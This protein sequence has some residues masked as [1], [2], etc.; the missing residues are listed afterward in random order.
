MIGQ[1]LLHYEVVGKLGEGGMGVVYKARDTHLDRFVAIKVLPPEKVADP[2]RRRRFVQEAKAA[3]ALNHPNI[4]TVH[5]TGEAGGS[6]FIVMEYVPGRTL[7][8]LISGKGMALKEALRYAVQIAD[9]L[10]AAH[11]AGIIHRDIK[12]GNVMVTPK[13]LVKVLD[14]GLAKLTEAGALG[15]DE[16]TRTLAPATGE[17]TIVGTAAYMSPEQAEG[18]A[19]DARSDIFSLGAVLYEMVTGRRAFQRDSKASTLVAIITQEPG[20]LPSSVPGELERIIARC[21]RKD[22]ER[23]FQFMKDLK[24][25]LEEL[26]EESESGTAALGA[27]QPAATPL[28][29]RRL[30]YG[31]GAVAAAGAAAVATRAIWA[32]SAAAKLR[33]FAVMLI[34]N[35][36]GESS[37][38]WMDRGLCELLITALAQ[39]QALAVLSTEVVRSAAAH[40]F[41]DNGRLTAERARDVA[42]DTHADLYASGALFKLGPGFRLSLRAQETESGKLVYTGTVE[43]ADA[44][45][46]FGMTDQA[47]AAMLAQIAPRSQARPDSA[48][49][50]TSNLEALKA[51]TEAGIYADQW[52]MDRAEEEIRRAV[53]LDPDFAMAQSRLALISETN[54]L[55]SLANCDLPAARAAAARAVAISQRRPLPIAHARFIQ[56]VALEVDGRVE[57]SLKVLEAARKEVPQDWQICQSLSDTYS[58]LG[59]FSDAISTTEE[60]AR[61]N[62]NAAETYLSGAYTYAESGDLPRALQFIERYASLVPPNNWNAAATRGDILSCNEHYDEALEQ[63]RIAD[64]IVPASVGFALVKLPAILGRIGEAEAYLEALPKDWRRPTRFDA[65]VQ[66]RKGNLDGA[67]AS[68]EGYMRQGDQT[69]WALWPYT[70]HAGNLLLEQR[71]PEQAL[72]LGKRL[73]NPWAPGLRGAAHLILGDEGAPQADFAELRKGT[74][75]IVGDFMA[76]TTE[77]LWRV[78]AASY[79]GRHGEVADLCS[80][81]TR[82]RNRARW[83]YSLDLVRALLALGRLADAEAELTSLI[84]HLLDLGGGPDTDRQFSMLTYLLARYHLAQVRERTGRRAE[85]AEWYRFFLSSFEHSAAKL[86][87]IAEARA[88]LKRL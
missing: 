86:P 30:M 42:R 73:P 85:A 1:R 23:R 80:R 33:T 67:L 36:T 56:S 69:R 64:K 20:P 49:G 68:Y 7:S 87:Q 19:V 38:D 6:V 51:Y 54:A 78:R 11:E 43:G 76:R 57:E 47:A 55:M 79:L 28:S 53:E 22:P 84:R 34:E 35:L 62:P 82:S 44:Q 58:Q 37:L 41:R 50:L 46:L 70:W 83:A 48:G 4:I 66:T 88:A 45:A 63:Y 25:E 72:A 18:K 74:A 31:A 17:G 27:P 29:R 9:A 15:E 60:A 26:K 8:D 3:S 77:S 12:P 65:D 13:G 10:A 39:S 14:F 52:L 71:D 5:D 16:S 75:P 32:P 61:L 21:L 24:V 40:R 81:L 59:R 2:E